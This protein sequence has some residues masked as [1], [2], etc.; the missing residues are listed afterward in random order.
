MSG[1]PDIAGAVKRYGAELVIV[2]VGVYAAFWVDNYRDS[3][4]DEETREG[5]EGAH[6]EA[7]AG[8]T[9]PQCLRQPN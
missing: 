9:R 7:S 2:F 1:R 6:G 3:K 4:H 8:T 5:E